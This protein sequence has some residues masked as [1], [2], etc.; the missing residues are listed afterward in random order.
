[1][2]KPSDHPIGEREILALVRRRAERNLAVEGEKLTI[3]DVWLPM[4]S[5]LRQ[6]EWTVMVRWT[7]TDVPTADD[8]I[9][10]A[11]VKDGVLVGDIWGPE[12]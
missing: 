6:Y 8:A 5:D 10:T 2:T 9:Y 3:S 1:V 7:R 11:W 4:R 12:W